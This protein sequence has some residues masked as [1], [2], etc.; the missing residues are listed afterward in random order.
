[1]VDASSSQQ[2]QAGVM[3]AAAEKLSKEHMQV[4]DDPSHD[5]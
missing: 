2:S 3:L 5:W 4:Y 1:M